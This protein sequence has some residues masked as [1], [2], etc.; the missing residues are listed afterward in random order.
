MKVLVADKFEAS[1]VEGLRAA[2]CEVLVNPD[3][4]AEELPAAMADIDPHVL[5]VR[6]TKVQAGVFKKHRRLSLIVRAGAG[7][8]T[9]DVAAASAAGVY[10]ANCPGKNSVAV[11]ELTWGLILAC[12]RMIPAQ[13][14]ELREGK[15]NKKTWSKAKGLKGRTLAVIGVGQIGQAVAIRGLQ[16]EMDVVGWDRSF[17]AEKADALGMV[18]AHTMREAIE[19]ADVVSVH[20]PAMP[21]TR[22]LIGPEFCGALREG[23]ILVN[24][25]RGSV[26]DEAA[27]IAAMREKGVRVGLD[28]YPD[29]PAAGD[30]TS[31][32]AIAREPGFVG[33]HHIGASTTQ[34]QEAIAAET[35]RVI[36]TYKTTGVVPNV[37]NRQTKSAATRQLSVRHLNR[38]GVLAHV[39]G[40]IGRAGIN[41]EEMENVIYDGAE[42]A[43]A[44]I[45]LDDEP[46]DDT[47]RA[48]NEGSEHVLSVDLTVI[49]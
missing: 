13:T 9:I 3:L 20:V 21:E 26:M 29:E 22:G 4:T 17:H 31:D 38:P 45:Q 44:R 33:T 5:V 48:I 35:V 30:A 23:A 10:V 1:G 19:Q 47:M 16:F 8:D 12:D 46:S 2:G 32:I 39:V 43:C 6:S 27:V 41:I 40:E 14:Q 49:E 18:H 11:A 15:W 42:A 34:A 28:V 36:E 24:T 7:Y 37:V 25:T